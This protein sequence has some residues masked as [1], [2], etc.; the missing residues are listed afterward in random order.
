MD[1]T[2]SCD[3]ILDMKNT[4]QKYRPTAKRNIIVFSDILRINCIDELGG[5]GMISK[6]VGGRKRREFLTN[7]RK[8]NSYNILK[9]YDT[10]HGR[11]REVAYL[12][13]RRHSIKTNVKGKK[14]QT[15]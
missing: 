15:L 10:Q 13:R 8:G 1:N 14:A 2:V 3:G 12:H 7:L 5:E 4:W 6:R 9:G 11:M